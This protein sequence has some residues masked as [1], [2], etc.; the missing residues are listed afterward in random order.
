[1]ST[2]RVAKIKLYYISPRDI[3]KARVDPIVMMKTCA[4]LSRNGIDV[5][6]IYPFY[7][8]KNNLKKSE[9]GKAYKIDGEL[10]DRVKLPTVLWDSAPVFWVRLNK[11]MLHFFYAF[12]ILIKAIFSSAK[13]KKVIFSRCLIGTVPYLLILKPFKKLLN[14][15]FFF[16][17][18]TYNNNLNQK[19]V[20]KNQDSIICISESLRSIICK[21]M[22]YPKERT[23]IAKCSAELDDYENKSKDLCKAECRLPNDKFIITYT[24]KVYYG[25]KEIDYIIETAKLLKDMLFIIVGGKEDQIQKF[26]VKCN[27]EEIKNVLFPGFVNMEKVQQY[28]IASDVL[29]LYYPGDWPIKDFLS[30]GKMIEYMATGNAI[31]SVN[32][33][34]LTEVL[35]N[36]YNALVIEPD[37]PQLLAEAILRLK[38]DTVLFETI[39]KNAK[40]DSFKY[41]WDS[42]AE[43]IT[44]KILEN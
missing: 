9:L 35:I 27:N 42:R 43:I 24:G 14:I 28:Q 15:D 6:L 10:F 37:N 1:V 34:S 25:M 3:L 30:P 16:E 33:K 4:S 36:E 2:D 12:I 31:I 38:N 29:V 5:K 44:N 8:R 11:I 26:I 41:S 18:H 23:A 17:L 13:D 32:F 19:I 7:F 39:S 40:K 22:L 21:K 20:L